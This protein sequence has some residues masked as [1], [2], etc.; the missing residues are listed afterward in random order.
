MPLIATSKLPPPED[1]QEF[2]SMTRDVLSERWSSPNLEMNG[3]QGQEQAGVDIYGA[4]HKNIFVGVQCKNTDNLNL[5]TVVD[6][7]AKAEAFEPSIKVFYIATTGKRNSKLQKSVRIESKKRKAEGKFRIHLLFWED[8]QSEIAKS[9]LLFQKYYSQFITNLPTQPSVSGNRNISALDLGFYGLNIRRIMGISFGDWGSS[10]KD[11][12]EFSSMLDLLEEAITVIASV[13]QLPKRLDTLS[14][15]K[16]EIDKVC[17]GRVKSWKN[18][19]EFAEKLEVTIRNLNRWLG[20]EEIKLFTIGAQLG[21]WENYDLYHYED[22][23]SQE[24]LDLLKERIKEVL[25]A[26]KIPKEID[27]YIK[28]Y[29]DQDSE[30]GKRSNAP[31]RS[32]NWLR[33]Y[34]MTNQ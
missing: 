9:K 14:K 13:E 27:Q 11:I 8:I 10:E 1:W 23:Y 4:N 34:Y 29:L 32:F 25:A 26:K 33:Q 19:N 6:E 22:S 12:R 30:F 2:E 15:F 7:V 31:T 28:D 20:P 5:Q 17:E 16:N 24:K 21:T 18:A 3:R